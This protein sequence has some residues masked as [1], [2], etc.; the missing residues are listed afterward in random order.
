VEVGTNLMDRTR[1]GTISS[2]ASQVDF[3]N[4]ALADSY[5]RSIERG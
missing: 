4:S 5:S 2:A 1:F 3:P